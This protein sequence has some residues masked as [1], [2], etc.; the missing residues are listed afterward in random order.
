M[1]IRADSKRRELEFKEG[2][3]V[4]VKL[5]PYRQHSVALR[6]NQKLSMKYFGPFPI[7]QRIGKVAYKLQLP[8]TA[9]IHPVFHISIL[10]KC[11]GTPAQ[12]NVPT[13]LSL[14]EKG[15]RLYPH[16]VLG[17][18]MIKNNG[19]WQEQVLIKWQQLSEEEA[20]WES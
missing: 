10:K 15:C 12:A 7:I 13:P 18:R 9:R 5:H 14:D 3:F 11:E 8:S 1:K 2:D 17:H 20:T 19:K 16:I 4:Y 6:K